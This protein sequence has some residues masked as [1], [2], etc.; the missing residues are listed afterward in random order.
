V[1]ILRDDPV[2]NCLTEICKV[3]R[4]AMIIKRG[5]VS[6]GFIK[7]KCGGFSFISKN[8]K[9]VT[10]WFLIDGVRSLLQDSRAEL[11]SVL[12]LDVEE[13]GDGKRWLSQFGTFWEA[14]TLDLINS[15]RGYLRSRLLEQDI[16]RPR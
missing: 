8:I 9:L 3:R 10:A 5:G 15:D 7:K 6:I 1:Y 13:D 11:L 4:L 14:V 16:R 2:S 12:R